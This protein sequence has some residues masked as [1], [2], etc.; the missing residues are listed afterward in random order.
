MLF[1]FIA[2]AASAF[3]LAGIAMFLRVITRN[4]L[5]KWI[6]PAAAGIGMLGYAIWNEYTWYPRMIMGLPAEVTVVSAPE[7]SQFYRPWSLF[8]PLVLRFVAYDGVNVLRSTEVDGIL[9][10]DAVFVTRWHPVQRVRVAFDCKAGKQALLV[11]GAT[12][13]PNGTLTGAEWFAP[14]AEDELQAAACKEG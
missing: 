10:G 5:P 14:P 8:K 1:D 13:A 12:L 4:L 6:I 11:D 7:E 2:A 3:A 9:Q